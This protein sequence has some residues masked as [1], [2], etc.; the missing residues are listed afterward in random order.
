MHFVTLTSDWNKDDYYTGAIKGT[1]LSACKDVQIVTLSNTI[2]TYSISEAAF[3]V[4]NSC[5]HFPPGTIH[6]IAVGSDP[7]P[8][9]N[10]LAAKMDGHYF[11]TA[12]NGILGLLGDAESSEVIILDDSKSNDAH[13]F[14]ALRSF[15][16][17]AC[18]IINGEDL[19]KIGTV[20][21]E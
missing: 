4:R 14:P 3:V 20:T 5:Y 2:K 15:S 13:S 18:R 1:I 6:I 8:G 9:S 17:V 7:A 16:K 21:T 19:S 11:L 12:D 10:L